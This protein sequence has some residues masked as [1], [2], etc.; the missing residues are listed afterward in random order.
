MFT[1]AGV[2]V[3]IGDA[4]HGGVSNDDV[5]FEDAVELVIGFAAGTIWSDAEKVSE[6]GATQREASE[7]LE[8]ADRDGE[9]LVEVIFEDFVS[10][11]GMGFAWE[12]VVEMVCEEFE[13]KA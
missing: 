12:G 1:G 13:Q 10:V 11:L 2:D 8:V 7:T 3:A 5:T 6:G 9:I 4:E